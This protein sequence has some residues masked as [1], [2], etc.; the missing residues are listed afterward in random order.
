MERDYVYEPGDFGGLIAMLLHMDLMFDVFDNHTIVHSKL[1]LRVND[2]PLSKLELNARSLEIHKVESSSGKIRFEYKPGE[3]KLIIAFDNPLVPRSEFIITTQTTC[4]PTKNVLEGLYYDETP[5]G[6]PPTIITQCQQWGFERLVPCMDDMTAKCTYTTKIIANAKYTHMISNGDIAQARKLLGNGRATITYAN[7]KTPMAPYLFFLG[8]G[9]YDVYQRECEYADGDACT[10]ELLVFPGSDPHAAKK[11]LEML[12]NAV[13]WVHLFTGP[14]KYEHWEEKKA[15]YRLLEERD[16]HK[17]AGDTEKLEAVRSEIRK[18]ISKW[19]LG[20]KYTGNVYREIAMQNSDFGG[21]ENVGNTTITANK[22]MPFNDLTDA[23]FEYMIIVKVH[24]F[25]HNLN[26]SEVTGWSPFELWLNE[27]VTVHIE[28][29]YFADMIGADYERLDSVLVLLSPAGGTFEQDTGVAVM[30]IEPDGFNDP[31]ELITNVTYSK[32]PEFVRMIELL[33][34]K[35][36]FVKALHRYHKKFRHKNATRAQWIECM[37]EV[38]GLGLK[39]MAE[40]WLKQTGYP[41]VHVRTSYDEKMKQCL[42]SVEQKGFRPGMHWEFPF[43]VAAH[44]K[45]GKLISSRMYVVKQPREKLVLEAPEKPAFFS[46]A[47]GLSF[48]GKLVH[49]NLGRDELLLQARLD[50]DMVNR[51]LAFYRLADDEKMRL[52]KDQHAEPSQGFIDMFYDMLSDGALM[53]RVGPLVLAITQSVEDEK[54]NHQ[55][56]FVY[57]A[58]RRILLGI[59]MKYKAG[60]LKVYA[61]YGKKRFAGKIAGNYVRSEL[62]GIKMRMVKNMC[63]SL[64]VLLDTHDIHSI[65]RRQYSAAG[66]ASDRL[67]AFKLYLE[68]TAKDRLD[69]FRE[70][71]ALS[72]KSLVAWENFLATVAGSESDDALQ[73]I[74]RVESSHYFRIEQSNDQRSL[75]MRFSRNK[76][77]SLL[78]SQGRA[79]MRQT[80]LKLSQINEFTAVHMLSIYGKLDYLE[81]VDQVE[82]T[83]VLTGLLASLDRRKFPG[84]CNTVRRILKG[85]PKSC[86]AY[87]KATGKMALGS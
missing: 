35:E 44:D 1:K 9:T 78:T 55:Y 8:V 62:Y 86:A 58:R 65:I 71:E 63:L 54:Y 51:Y 53:E 68:S 31:N 27:A 21:M 67:A 15:V 43:D 5:D 37:E 72:Q 22:I 48:Y 59:A 57:Q 46:L 50:P 30:P 25:Y 45:E 16:A 40:V 11:A 87:K 32:A 42:F 3:N 10:L 33:L 26:G 47:R 76:R 20:Y 61:E 69:M 4:R 34:G 49:E 23:G 80:L 74:K 52:I 6:A 64:L 2:K 29:E 36:Q 70:C 81:G 39:R 17:F 12:Y 83:K 82:N 38:S 7:T 79:F 60:L 41:T 75:Y 73:L 28:K 77:K 66:C 14:K 18:R 13:M 85:S 56:E 19:T 24:E 84:V